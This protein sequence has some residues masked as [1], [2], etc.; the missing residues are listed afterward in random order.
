MNNYTPGSKTDLMVSALVAPQG[1]CQNT[2]RAKSE[3]LFAPEALGVLTVG[4]IH[5]D[6]RSVF[7]R[8]AVQR[9]AIRS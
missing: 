9:R 3:A 5:R 7:Q 8:L 2:E 1:N 4:F 6:K